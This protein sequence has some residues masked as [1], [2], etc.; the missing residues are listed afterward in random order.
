MRMA[1]C[2]WSSTLLVMVFCAPSGWCQVDT[3]KALPAMDEVGFETKDRVEL[4]A[5][6]YASNDGKEAVPIIMLHA[7][8]PK[9]S[10]ADYH[11]L[12]LEMQKY[13]HAVLVPDLRGHGASTAWTNPQGQAVK[14]TPDKVEKALPGLGV[15]VEECKKFLMAKHRAGQL[16]IDRLVIVA[17][18]ESTVVAIN[19]TAADW[20]YVPLAGKKQGQDVKA[21]VLLSPM[22]QFKTLNINEAVKSPAIQKAVWA[23]CIV[24]KKG[25]T[26]VV[27]ECDRI[28][29]VLAKGHVVDPPKDEPEKRD[30]HQ[31]EADTQTQGTQMLT[32]ANLEL[33]KRIGKFINDGVAL[34]KEYNWK[35]R[36]ANSGTP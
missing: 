34:K 36:N 12:A 7:F 23:Y 1:I 6:Y 32:V 33:S 22:W 11:T 28:Y 21:L 4:V 16:N 5:S 31:F 17:A 27:Q 3:K 24:G 26:T 15:D 10:R 30:L 19:Y 25:K 9:H 13:G 29:N 20:S 8:G 18:E 35:E 14:L 2:V